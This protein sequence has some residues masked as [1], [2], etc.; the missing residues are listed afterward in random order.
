MSTKVG[1]QISWPNW[2]HQVRHHRVSQVGKHLLKPKYLPSRIRKLQD[3]DLLRYSCRGTRISSLIDYI[4]KG[5][6]MI[7]E[8]RSSS[9]KVNKWKFNKSC[10]IWLSNLKFP[11]LL[12]PRE[13]MR[14]SQFMS[15]SSWKQNERQRILRQGKETACWAPVQVK[16]ERR[17]QRNRVA[18]SSRHS[19]FL[20]RPQR[21]CILMQRGIRLKRWK[22]TVVTEEK[23]IL[24][25]WKSSSSAIWKTSETREMPV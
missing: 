15:A 2:E 5:R 11:E 21:S 1:P 3:Q 8:G 20:R 4:K 13:Q 7:R 25:R 14:L 22:R 23:A 12:S 16:R 6:S 18:P 10:R 19:W 17:R 24:I 9:K